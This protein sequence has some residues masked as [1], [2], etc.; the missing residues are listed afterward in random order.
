ML[1]LFVVPVYAQVKGDPADRLPDSTRKLSEVSLKG[2]AAHLLQQHP[3]N[4][5]VIGLKPYYST[6]ITPVQL[7][8]STA[9]VKVRQ[10]GGYGSRVDFFINGSTGKQLKFFLDGLPLDHLGETS[11]INNLPVEQIDRI[12][13]YK[14]VIPVDLGADVLGG[15]VNIVTR[16][17]RE[18]YI[19]ASYGLSSFGSHKGNLSVRRNWTGRFFT[20]VNAYSGYAKNN[21]TIDAANIS[22]SSQLE[23]IRVKRFHDRYKNYLVKAEAGLRNLRWADELSVSLSR[24]G[25]D[26]ELQN[27][28]TMSQPYAKAT[29]GEGLTAAMLKYQKNGLLK[30][31][32]LSGFLSASHVHGLFTDTSANVITWDGRIADRRLKGAELGPAAMRNTYTDAYA[33]RLSASWWLSDQ[34]RFIASSTINRY[35]R[36]GK[37]ELAARL[38]GDDLYSAPSSQWKNVAGLGF[39]GAA[40]DRLKW[41]ASLKNFFARMN[42]FSV[43]FD[44]RVSTVQ[45]NSYW[46]YGAASTWDA[47]KGILLKA[48]FE[49]AVRLPDVEESFGDLMLLNPNPSLKAEESD[50]LNLN[51]VYGGDHLDVEA[52]GFL[53]NVDHLIFLV[54]NSQGSAKA[55][56][57]L[58]AGVEGVEV[59]ANYRLP[60][61]LAL[62]ANATYQDLRN[63]SSIENEGIPNERYKDQRIPN[64]PYLLGNAGLSFNRPVAKKA[65]FSAWYT[66]N[67]THDY[68]LYWAI[69]GDPAQKHVIP[70][71]LLQNVGVSF[72]FPLLSFSLESYNL[73]DAKTYDNFRSQLPGR[74]FSLKTRLYLH[75]LK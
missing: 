27:N 5:T 38:T 20:T 34:S 58:R 57:L 22:A 64:I 30:H 42:G 26:R 41:S 32:N 40:G 43:V 3:G 2:T 46:G 54:P 31:L 13:I 62:N 65:G 15:A 12:E 17:D 19:D 52:G 75:Q 71:Q 73:A 28:L 56:N 59:S 61:G 48:S 16:K 4:V 8:R 49:H 69:D 68:F 50:N 24:S 67:Y 25:L 44:K 74:S 11:G 14:G 21:Y 33:A 70:Q 9:G 53:R 51:I 39:E 47:G 7:L 1:L 37:D 36:T 6:N 10:D 63:Q 29:Y 23:N 35:Q 66:I 72:S 55:Y 18:D 60:K 45:S